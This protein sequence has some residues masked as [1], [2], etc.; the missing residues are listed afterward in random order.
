MARAFNVREGFSRKDDRLPDIFFQ[1]MKGGALDGVSIS[2]DEFEQSL[3][4][5]YEMK[6]WD[7]TTGAPTRGKL[8][9]LDIG[10]VYGKMQ[11]RAR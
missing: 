8:E 9:E 11:E 5:L 3:T 10:W 4:M 2:K 6:G 7:T 1:P